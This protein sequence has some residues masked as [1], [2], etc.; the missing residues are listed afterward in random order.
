MPNSVS[1]FVSKKFKHFQFQL[2][3]SPLTHS[4]AHSYTQLTCEREREKEMNGRKRG[5]EGRGKKFGA[6]T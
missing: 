3:P 1:C 4:P 5:A 6:C 2:N